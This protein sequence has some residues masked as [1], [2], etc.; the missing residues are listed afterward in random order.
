MAQVGD[1][2]NLVTTCR[3]TND[4]T[5]NVNVYWYRISTLGS[6]NPCVFVEA[7]FR[8]NIWPLLATITSDSYHL[9]QVS[10]VNWRDPSEFLEEAYAEGALNGDLPGDYLPSHYTYNFT[11]RKDRPGRRPGL[12]QLAGVSEILITSAGVNTDYLDEIDA[13]E[14]ALESAFTSGGFTFVPVVVQR[15]VQGVNV[16]PLLG[17][18]NPQNWQPS[19]VVFAGFGHRDTRK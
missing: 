15:V 7:T 3:Y 1:I 2:I 16:M 6:G 8:L 18:G 19:G 17:A 4:L 13:I 9:R 11:Y 14:T 5:S 10:C 12:K